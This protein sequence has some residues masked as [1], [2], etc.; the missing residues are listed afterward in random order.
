[1][2]RIFATSTKITSE[3][4]SHKDQND[5]FE[6]V[7]SK[8][9]KNGSKEK[10]SCLIDKVTEEDRRHKTDS[11]KPAHFFVILGYYFYP[12][13]NFSFNSLLEVRFMSPS[14]LYFFYL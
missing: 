5:G 2:G 9:T 12:F 14:V 3:D 1:M 8:K 13:S 10:G 6:L 11:C 7:V 4:D